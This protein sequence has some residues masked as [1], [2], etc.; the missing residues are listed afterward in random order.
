[1]EPYTGKC[2]NRRMKKLNYSKDYKIYGCGYHEKTFY[3]HYNTR[4]FIELSVPYSIFY[5][6]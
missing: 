6:E 2:C 3:K 1:M 5:E 4:K